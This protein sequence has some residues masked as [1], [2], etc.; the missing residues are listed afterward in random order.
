[1]TPRRTP[2][3]AGWMIL[4][5]ALALTLPRL[6]AL[7]ADSGDEKK[8][9]D[10]YLTVNGAFRAA[11]SKTKKDLIHAADPVMLEEGGKLVLL[12]AG[13]RSEREYQS[14]RYDEVKTICHV[15]LA[16]HV[17]LLNQSDLGDEPTADLGRF[18][19]KV[20][21]AQKSLKERGFEGDLLSRQEKILTDSLAFLDGVVKRRKV[22][23]EE[24]KTFTL[25]MGKQMTPLVD[26]IAGLQLDTLDAAVQTLRKE[27]TDE[28]WQGLK[29]VVMGSAMPRQGHIVVQY[30]ARLLG[31]PGE[32]RRIIYAEG[33]W[34]EDKALDLLGKHLLDGP[35]GRDF[36]GDDRRM[37]RD[38]LA[39]AAKEHLA[40]KERKP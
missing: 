17:M 9:R 30:F 8:P 26:Y 4:G 19:E 33:L 25:D 37:M 13:K 11:Y 23:A 20:V 24:T 29:V 14:P 39:D 7:A 32:G 28:E 6:A 22:S 21:A 10:P 36:F 38:L 3:A 2:S 16:L 35:I 34:T 18:R 27:L 40:K 5:A 15:P 1:M 31:E 12:H